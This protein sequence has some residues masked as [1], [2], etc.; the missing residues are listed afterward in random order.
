MGVGLRP[1]EKSIDTPPNPNDARA[2]FLPDHGKSQ[3]HVAWM[4]GGGGNVAF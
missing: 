4:T 3:S 2:V 1:M